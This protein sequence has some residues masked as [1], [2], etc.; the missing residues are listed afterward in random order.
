V[1]SIFEMRE[2]VHLQGHDDADH[3]AREAAIKAGGPVS[4]PV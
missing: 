2:L 3:A 1:I 4:R